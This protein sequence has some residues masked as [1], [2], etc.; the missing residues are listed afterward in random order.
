MTEPAP[1]P[2]ETRP[3]DPHARWRFFRDVLV[4]QLKLVLGNLHNFIFVPISLLAA[5]ADM[6]FKSG[7]QGSRFY[8][9][10]AWA[11]D[12]DHAIGLYSA[13]EDE[14]QRA[15]RTYSVDSVVGRIEQVIVREYERGGT[16]ASVKAAVDRALDKMQ[17]ET[18]AKYNPEEIVK[19]AAEKIREKMQQRRAGTS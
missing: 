1:Q 11:R 5:A 4:F 19:R 2:P 9:T 10:M 3:D 13:L 14:E 18:P 6:L 7:Q 12:A 8:K 15:A 16:T 17:R